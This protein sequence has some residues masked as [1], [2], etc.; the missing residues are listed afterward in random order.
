MCKKGDK[1][2]FSH[3]LNVVRKVEKRNVYEHKDDGNYISHL[4]SRH[5]NNEYT[6]KYAPYFHLTLRIL[7]ISL[8]YSMK[9]IVTIINYLLFSAFWCCG[10]LILYRSIQ[11]CRYIIYFQCFVLLLYF[12]LRNLQINVEHRNRLLLLV[13]TE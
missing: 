4:T 2:K 1:C 11:Q 8:I 13:T 5:T 3:D 7:L 10:I 9:I 12:I 6:L